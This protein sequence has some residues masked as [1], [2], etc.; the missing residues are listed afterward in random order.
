MFMDR[1]AFFK[2][3]V[4]AINT[5]NKSS[6]PGN[7]KESSNILKR[8]RSKVT[9]EFGL[10]AAHVK[11]SVSK[12]KEF[13]LE[14]R[15]DYINAVSHVA[16][17]TT[18]SNTER[19]Q[20]DEDAE[21]FIRTCSTA[22]QSLKEEV[23]NQKNTELVNE[24]RFI[25]LEILQKY[26][27]ATCKLYSEQRA[28]RVK[29]VVEKKKISRLRNDVIHKPPAN[30]PIMEESSSTTISNEREDFSQEE[31]QTFEEENKRMLDEM[32]S[33]ASEVRNIEGQVVEIA[34]LQE[35][36]SEKVLE[37]SKQIDQV[38]ETTV[39]TTENVKDGNENIREAIKN[40]ASFRVWILFFLVMCS[41]SLLFLDWYS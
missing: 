20:I 9:T 37:Q 26:L 5:R 17:S 41:F 6:N 27:K 18:M 32:N 7:S 8:S 35:V 14:H 25:V 19:D 11:Q 38:Y 16:S 10:K 24:H 40:N 23:A 13:L 15:K 28:I 2:A 33:L 29:R 22:I 34:K 30:S 3:C 1:T 31:L 39:K 36:F 4:K 12:L 21:T